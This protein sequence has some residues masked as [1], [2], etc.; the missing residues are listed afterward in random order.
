MSELFEII[1]TAAT[2]IAAVLTIYAVGTFLGMWGH[3]L[4]DI[5]YQATRGLLR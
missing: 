5:V 3:G 4:D 2:V 1:L